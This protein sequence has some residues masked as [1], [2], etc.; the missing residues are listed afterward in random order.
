MTS[1]SLPDQ[2]VKGGNTSY[3]VVCNK[4]KRIINPKYSHVSDN[5]TVNSSKMQEKERERKY[6]LTGKIQESTNCE[7]R[8]AH[9]PDNDGMITSSNSD[10]TIREAVWYIDENGLVARK[11]F[12]PRKRLLPYSMESFKEPFKA[13]S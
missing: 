2:K 10:V 6:E 3:S 12:V 5:Y 8:L 13:C 11:R 4:G 7:S 9:R 1:S